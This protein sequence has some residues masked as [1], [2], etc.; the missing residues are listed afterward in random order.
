LSGLFANKR[1]YQCEIR[2]GEN[3]DYEIGLRKFRKQVSTSLA[4]VGRGAERLVTVAREGRPKDVVERT[5][6]SGRPDGPYVGCCGREA[7][8]QSESG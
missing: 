3:E 2:L 5:D 6:R 8:G 1:S 4:R 7:R